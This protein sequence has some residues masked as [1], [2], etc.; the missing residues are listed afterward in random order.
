MV[1]FITGGARS[2]KSRFAEAMAGRLSLSGEGDYIATA[3]L[4]DNE[5]EERARLHRQRRAE[6]GF[7]WRL[8][9]EPYELAALLAERSARFREGETGGVVLIDCLTLWLSNWLLKLER[10]ER[11]DRLEAQIEE[12]SAALADCPMPVLVVSNEVGDGIVPEYELGRLFRDYAGL[13]GQR[14]ARL[15]DRAFLVTAGIPVDLKRL[16]FNLDDWER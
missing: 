10:E 4:Y 16:E 6:S 15:S 12:L 3:Q 14:I 7:R 5:M 1:I 8:H 2:G 11:L 13:L 9:E